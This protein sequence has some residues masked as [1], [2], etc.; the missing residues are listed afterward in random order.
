M[1]LIEVRDPTA[2]LAFAARILDSEWE[3]ITLLP[4]LLPR[5]WRVYVDGNHFTGRK[6]SPDGQREH[7][8]LHDYYSHK[9]IGEIWKEVKA[10][11]EPTRWGNDELVCPGCALRWDTNEEKPSC[12]RK[13]QSPSS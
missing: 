9:P 11:P 13:T 5:G 10:C 12:P 7:D 6:R 3:A 4:D 1:I 2:E 8:R